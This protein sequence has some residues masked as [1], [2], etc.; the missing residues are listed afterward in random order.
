MSARNPPGGGVLPFV[1]SLVAAPDALAAVLATVEGCPGAGSGVVPV[2]A[3]GCGAGVAPV[4]VAPA[5]VGAVP[6]G[7]ARLASAGVERLVVLGEGRRRERMEASSV[8]VSTESGERGLEMSDAMVLF[9]SCSC[10]VCGFDR[11]G[12]C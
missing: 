7:P 2:T 6:V 9:W 8:R 3:P 12:R 4:V 10:L 11:R 1:V 5:A